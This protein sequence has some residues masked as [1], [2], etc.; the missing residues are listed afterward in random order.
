MSQ[1]SHRLIML[2][3]MRT[4][5]SGYA[6]LQT[7]AGQLQLQVH[8]RGL[9]CEAARVFWYLSG[10]EALELGQVRVNPRG[11]AS[12]TAD[13][14]DS[15]LAPERMQAL[16]VLSGGIKP[17][18]LLIGLCVEQSAGSILDAKNAA[19]ALCERL[20]RDEGKRRRAQE[21]ATAGAEAAHTNKTLAYEAGRMV[22]D[23]PPTA[24]AATARAAG[25]AQSVVPSPYNTT[26]ASPAASAPLAACANAASVSADSLS[27]PAASHKSEV[28]REIFL[29]AIDA[30][31]YVQSMRREGAPPTEPLVPP[32][33]SPP[34]A[35][36]LRPLKWPRG[37]E[38]VRAYFEGGV[39]CALFPLP[40]WRFVRAAQSGG[41]EGLWIG[42]TQLDGRVR[43]VAYA[44]RGDTPPPGG[45]PYRPAR[46]LDGHLYQ[47]LWQQV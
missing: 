37:F 17:E 10:G 8:A 11:E 40:G 27:A 21:Q 9:K 42:Y 19:L 22:S 13:M 28:P 18:S 2:K 29:P 7:G 36:R 30:A 35:D 31:A 34:K 6:R 46:G 41:P 23:A 24:P 4:G 15:R 1:I 20:Y 32:P 38:R 3:P 45:K 44:I 33:H 25:N 16:L 12:L 26:E 5:V 47:V 43:Q 14:P 39:P